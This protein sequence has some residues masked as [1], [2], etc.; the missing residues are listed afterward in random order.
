MVLRVT[1][2]LMGTLRRMRIVSEI[3]SIHRAIA[4][5]PTNL[6]ELEETLGS[7]ASLADPVVLAAVPNAYR[8][9]CKEH[10]ALWEH[11][12]EQAHAGRHPSVLGDVAAEQLAA[13][14]S[15][16]RAIELMTGAGAPPRN[17]G[18]ENL[19]RTL[20]AANDAFL[21]VANV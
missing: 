21:R 6:D 7:G 5:A 20:R 19:A 2:L 17:A 13:A 8:A 9:S 14:G 3:E 10:C 16:D 15:I 1:G 11:C 18:E 12:R 4:E